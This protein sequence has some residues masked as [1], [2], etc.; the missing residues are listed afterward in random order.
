MPERA[1]DKPTIRPVRLLTRRS[2]FQAFASVA[3]TACDIPK[4]T[5]RSQPQD[6]GI[7]TKEVIRDARA[8]AIAAV[9]DAQT[10]KEDAEAD[11]ACKLP[12]LDSELQELAEGHKIKV[13][14]HDD[15]GKVIYEEITLD[16]ITGKN[17]ILYDCES[18]KEEMLWSFIKH[19][20]NKP[21]LQLEAIKRMTLSKSDLIMHIATKEGVEEY[22]KKPV[23]VMGTPPIQ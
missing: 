6:A 21:K 12:P 11:D 9:T 10:D 20:K 2:I 13:G 8:D 18:G 4:Q 16:G 19:T 5:E 23:M 3:L 15:D 14:Y 22:R 17:S 7:Q 1:S